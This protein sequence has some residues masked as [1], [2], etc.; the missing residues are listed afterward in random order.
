[1]CSE[2]T[3]TPKSRRSSPLRRLHVVAQLMLAY[4][5][6]NLFNKILKGDIPCHKIFETDHALAILDAFPLAPGHALLLPKAKCVSVLD[7][8][9][10]VAE[11]TALGALKKLKG[12][13]FVSLSTA[14]GSD[15][16]AKLALVEK[17]GLAKAGAGGDK[18]ISFV[19]NL[20]SMNPDPRMKM[21]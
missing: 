3:F 1:M 14:V 4:D 18:I 10:E 19:A 16:K 9:A 6:D 2:L 20:A 17:L 12:S 8:P 7:M 15:D 21:K 5:D 13:G 11:K